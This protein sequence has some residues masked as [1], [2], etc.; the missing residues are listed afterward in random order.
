MDVQQIKLRKNTCEFGQTVSFINPACYTG[1]IEQTPVITIHL[2]PINN[3]ENK[4]GY[5][6]VHTEF[7]PV[8]KHYN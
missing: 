2:P 4:K 7:T 3:P 1:E 5:V 6:T 8:L